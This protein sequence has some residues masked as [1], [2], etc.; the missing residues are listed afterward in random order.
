MLI[1][2]LQVNVQDERFSALFSSHLFNIDPTDSHYH[3]T[4]GM[5]AFRSEKLHRRQSDVND[6]P[7]VVSIM[8]DLPSQHYDEV[9]CNVSGMGRKF[10]DRISK[11]LLRLSNT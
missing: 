2:N 1:L 4:K 11:G 10:I 7:D 3:K 8:Y 6:N 5:E 9:L